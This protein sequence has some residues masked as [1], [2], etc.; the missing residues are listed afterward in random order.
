MQR[1][2]H[3]LTKFSERS[4]IQSELNELVCMQNSD[5]QVVCP[6]YRLQMAHVFPVG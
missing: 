2:L 6:V 4:K 3:F 1:G 5:L